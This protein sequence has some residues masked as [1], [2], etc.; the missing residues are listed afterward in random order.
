[1]NIIEVVGSTARGTIGSAWQGVHPFTNEELFADL[2]LASR[3]FERA[4]EPINV[5]KADV[6]L[7]ERAGRVHL[8]F[9]IA[10]DD[11]KLDATELRLE[12]PVE[13]SEV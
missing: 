7:A 4:A 1:M 13:T 5:V 10:A 6:R 3:K 8:D 12:C 9:R 11:A 2:G